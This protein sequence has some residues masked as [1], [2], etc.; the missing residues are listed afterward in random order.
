M[1]SIY[2]EDLKDHRS[3]EYHIV[4]SKLKAVKDFGE[5][6]FQHYAIRVALGAKQ[7]R[8]GDLYDNKGL[9]LIEGNEDYMA[10]FWKEFQKQV[11]ALSE[12][13]QWDYV[14]K[15]KLTS[16]N[17]PFREKN[18]FRENYHLPCKFLQRLMDEERLMDE[19]EDEEDE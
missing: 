19:D 4:K 15:E 1:K 14:N 13:I 5:K 11:V 2:K 10:R 17:N 16:E 12:I 7:Q 3:E 18:P 9:T 8:F 6:V